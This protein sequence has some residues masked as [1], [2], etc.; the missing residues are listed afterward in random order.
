MIEKDFMMPQLL[1]KSLLVFLPQQV[2]HNQNNKPQ[3]YCSFSYSTIE[4]SLFLFFIFLPNFHFSIYFFFSKLIF[5]VRNFVCVKVDEEQAR[6]L[7]REQR[8]KQREVEAEKTR[9][10]PQPQVQQ[11]T[12][13]PA[14]VAAPSV[15]LLL[16]GLSQQQSPQQMQQQ[17]VPQQQFTPSSADAFFSEFQT[18]STSTSFPT[19]CSFF[20]SP[21]FFL[22]FTYQHI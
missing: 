18:S 22:I 14:P 2:L 9:N 13:A 17:F 6:K 15:D 3:L 11:Y 8:R 1:Q 10:S 16:G 20:L 7:R 4:F 5:I 21:L 12:P 19:N